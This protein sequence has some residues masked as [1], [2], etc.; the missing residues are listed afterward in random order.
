MNEATLRAILAGH[1]RKILLIEG[2]ERL[3]ERS[4]RD[5]FADLLTLAADDKTLHIIL[6]VRDYS[7]EL[8]RSWFLDDNIEHSVIMFLN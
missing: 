3:F 6:T 5:A 1:D 2:V 4:T 8:V 7:T